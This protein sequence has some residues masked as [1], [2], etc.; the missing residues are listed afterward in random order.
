MTFSEALDAMKLGE[1]VTRNCWSSGSFVW[2]KPAAEVKEEWCKDEILKD[3][4]HKNGGSVYAHGTFCKLFGAITRSM[5]RDYILTGW[6][7]GIEDILAEDWDFFS[8]KPVPQFFTDEE[9]LD[10]D[11]LPEEDRVSPEDIDY[12]NARDEGFLDGLNDAINRK[13]DGAIK[14]GDADALKTMRRSLGISDQE[15][16]GLSHA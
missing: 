6:V 2:L 8:I 16:G 13:I 1:K 15:V 12:L 5:E 11:N 7:P 4:A 9:E 10:W 14:S 3:I